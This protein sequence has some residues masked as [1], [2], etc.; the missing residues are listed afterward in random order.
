ME[1]IVLRKLFQSLFAPSQN[2][3]LSARVA[4][5]GNLDYRSCL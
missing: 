3:A 5:N 4:Y 1:L 2:T